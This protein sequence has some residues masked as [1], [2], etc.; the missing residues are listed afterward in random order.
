[1]S[2]AQRAQDGFQTAATL[3]HV[4]PQRTAQRWQECAQRGLGLILTNSKLA[5]NLRD[6]LIATRVHQ[7]F[8]EIHKIH[9]L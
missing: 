3:R 6:R 2:A 9:R 5:R 8:Q 1:L 7:Q 4:T